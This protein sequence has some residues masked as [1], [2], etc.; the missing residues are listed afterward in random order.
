MK[1]WM[2]TPKRGR[3]RIAKAAKPVPVKVVRGDCTRVLQHEFGEAGVIEAYV[4]AEELDD[5]E[6]NFVIDS[7]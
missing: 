2:P 6:I 7:S 3:P 4:M 1:N 5:L